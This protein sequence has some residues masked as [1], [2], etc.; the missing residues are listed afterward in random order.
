[1]KAISVWQPWASAIAVGAKR[2]ETRS[3]N[4][5]YRGR[6]LIHASKRRLITELVEYEC[7]PCWRAALSP[8]GWAPGGDPIENIDR[9]PFGAIVAVADLAWCDR[10]EDF[11]DAE[12]G[13]IRTRAG[14]DSGTYYWTERMLGDFRAGR[15]GWRLGPIWRLDEPIPWRGRRGLFDIPTVDF[16]GVTYQRV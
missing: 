11:E 10:T 2:I 13:A 9:L 16:T 4:P 8:L 12:L 15:W 3:W 14:L 6:I 5:P 7:D 1:M